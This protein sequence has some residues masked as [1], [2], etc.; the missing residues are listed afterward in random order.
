MSSEKHVI[1]RI[2]CLLIVI[3]GLVASFSCLGASLT[4]TEVEDN[5]Y[6]MV[7]K[8]RQAVGLEVLARNHHLDELARQYSENGLSEYVEQ[9]TELRYLLRNS[10]WVTYDRGSP[11]LGEGTAREQVDYCLESDQLRETMFRSEARATGVGVAIVGDKVY[12]TQVFDVLNAAGGNGE[13]IRLSENTQATDSSWWQLREFLVADDTDEHLYI[14]DSFVCADFAAMLHDRAESA[15]IKTAYVSVDFTQGPGHALDAFN[16]TDRGLVYIDCT[17]PGLETVTSG[18]TLDSQE[19]TV[20]Y[21]KVAYIAIG[22]NYGLISLDKATS[23][24]YAFY[25][26]WTQQWQDYKTKVDLYNYGYVPPQK[27]EALRT[28]LE[29]QRGVL[30]EY[31]WEPLG[32]VSDVYIHW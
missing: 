27:R 9:F 17:G 22:R 32:V 24:D 5:I 14:P 4:E 7:N 8:E 13:P 28:E 31:S 2:M 1:L 18:N 21:D 19:N 3:F 6:V 10:W 25:E 26:Q 30:G 29:M 12:Y 23:F 15:G 20:D 11:R 16:T